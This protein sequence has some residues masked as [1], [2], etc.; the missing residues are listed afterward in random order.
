MFFI[1]LHNCLSLVESAFGEL[2]ELK[3]ELLEHD[4][5]PSLQ[6]AITLVTGKL[7]RR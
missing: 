7:F 3:D 2:L 4:L 1:G 5:P 6:V